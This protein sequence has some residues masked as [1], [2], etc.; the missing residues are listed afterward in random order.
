MSS[1]LCINLV[2]VVADFVI[3]IDETGDGLPLEL[4]SWSVAPEDAVEEVR[5]TCL[6]MLNSHL[7]KNEHRLMFNF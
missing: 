3:T 4:T 1:S 5:I 6:C 7:D 2:D